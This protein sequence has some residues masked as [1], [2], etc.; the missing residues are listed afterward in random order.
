M[1]DSKITALKAQYVDYFSDVPVQRYAAMYIG[2]NE[3]TII[4]WRKEDPDFADAIKKSNAI[5]IRKKLMETKAE[6]A[7]E[8]LE[9]SIFSQKL[10]A[11]YTT[12]YNLDPDGLNKVGGEGI[13]EAFGEFMMLKT[14]EQ[15]EQGNISEI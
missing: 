11:E 13:V 3:D 12:S 10:E 8:R 14:K 15:I 6:F 5:W 2:R 7:L 9:K 4:R 1:S